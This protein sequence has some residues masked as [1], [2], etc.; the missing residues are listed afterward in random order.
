VRSALAA[1][2]RLHYQAPGGTLLLQLLAAIVTIAGIVTTSVPAA[3]AGVLL[4][5]Y[6]RAAL[7]RDVLQCEFT[8]LLP[9]Y[10][11]MPR[12]LMVR[13]ALVAGLLVGLAG[14]DG[15]V[16]LSALEGIAVSLVT[17]A[18]TL[19]QP[20]MAIVILAALR[21][22]VADHLGTI[23]VEA[24]CAG[25]V[26]SILLTWRLL[27]SRVLESWIDRSPKTSVHVDLGTLR[28]NAEAA[29]ARGGAT[30]IG[31]LVLRA[32]AL[33][34][35]GADLRAMGA[36]VVSNSGRHPAARAVLML[37]LLVLVGG[38]T[39]A[40]NR[41]DGYVF[42]LFIL[43]WVPG[44]LLDWVRVPQ[45]LPIG[46]RRLMRAHF[47]LIAC[48]VVLCE[49]LLLTTA[50][51]AAVAGLIGVPAGT[52]RFAPMAL[53]CQ[54]LVL[55][56]TAIVGASTATLQRTR[57]GSAVYAVFMMACTPIAIVVAHADIVLLLAGTAVCA[58]LA[59]A[60]V[61]LRYARGDL[62]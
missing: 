4:L 33:G 48:A 6:A 51:V 61:R 58:S 5:T 50:A 11:D 46:R 24:L 45:A 42:V 27:D 56:P 37:A 54:G 23:P 7:Y 57:F 19:W 55:V 3:I 2:A 44:M 36:L 12:R 22:Q 60:A 59:Y 14:R 35:G 20:A 10:R 15:A 13:L 32:I 49:M 62:I 43:S 8:R 53:W 16:A 29:V 17:A 21:A 38:Y 34:T 30:T 9:G 52:M 41:G 47:L 39:T 1:N 28:R 26:V 31:D 25:S 18:L 40:T